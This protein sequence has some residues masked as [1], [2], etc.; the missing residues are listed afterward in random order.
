MLYIFRFDPGSLWS[1]KISEMVDGYV[2]YM[3]KVNSTFSSQDPVNLDRIDEPIRCAIELTSF[4]ELAMAPS[5][6]DVNG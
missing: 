1:H 6:A 2:I 4:F 3:R 5:S